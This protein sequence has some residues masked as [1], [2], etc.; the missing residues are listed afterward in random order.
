MVEQVKYWLIGLAVLSLAVIG[1]LSGLGPGQTADQQGDAQAAPS[2]STATWES[3]SPNFVA[4]E[5]EEEHGGGSGNRWGQ[6][7]VAEVC[8]EEGIDLDLAV[9]RLAAYEMPTGADLRIRELADSSGYKPSEVIDILS[10]EEPGAGC[11][12]PDCDHE[13]ESG[14][15]HE[16][17]EGSGESCD[18]EDCEE[19]ST[20]SEA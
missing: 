1:V 20:G 6:F 19:H 3:Q 8:Q 13:S 10:G 15:G 11:D 17:H 7:T 5:V 4:G 2:T 12:D 9:E 16:G 14:A 18:D